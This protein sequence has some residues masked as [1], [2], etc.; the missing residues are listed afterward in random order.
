MYFDVKAIFSL[1][2]TMI[3]YREEENYISVPSTEWN[4]GCPEHKVVCCDGYIFRSTSNNCLSK[5]AM[6]YM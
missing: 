5:S 2:S 3:A 1:I 4:N 6:T